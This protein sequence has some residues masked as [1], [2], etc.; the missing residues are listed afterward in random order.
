M[1]KD[2]L[3][4]TK[5]INAV[6]ESKTAIVK[7][8]KKNE[9]EPKDYTLNILNDETHFSISEAYKTARTNLMFALASEKGCKKIIVTS[10]QGGEGKSTTTSNLSIAFAQTGARVLVIEADLRRPKLHRYLSL[11]N[12][13]GMSE[14]LGGFNTIDDVLQHSEKY[15]LDCI[16]G[17]HVPPNP[18]ELLISAAFSE[19]L[20]TLSS[21]YDYIFVDSPPV[22]VVTDPVSI[23]KQMTGAILVAR[24]SYTT[25]DM[26]RKAIEALEFGQIK[27]LGYI[28]NGSKDFAGTSSQRYKGKYG[29]KGYYK[30]GYY[31]YG[32]FDENEEN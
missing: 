9:K 22:N 25:S 24:Q 13:I 29:Y 11:S 15:N 31:K 12:E 21:N 16:T 4:K 6:K 2:K 27:I 14:Y 8:N 18:S 5:N 20:E 32:Y 10:S 17:G 19:L 3:N 7:K 28:M 1:K 26:L 30:T 23:A